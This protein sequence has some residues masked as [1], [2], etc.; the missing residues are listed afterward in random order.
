M[1]TQFFH[2]QPQSIFQKTGWFFLWLFSQLVLALQK[3]IVKPLKQMYRG[4]I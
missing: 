4:Y 3:L 1:Q 2:F